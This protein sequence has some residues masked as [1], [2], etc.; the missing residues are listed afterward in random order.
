MSKV[1]DGMVFGSLLYGFVSGVLL[2]SGSQ[3]FS[4]AEIACQPFGIIMA[5]VLHQETNLGDV[6]QP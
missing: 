4:A 2:A 6:K 3:G 5:E 1:S